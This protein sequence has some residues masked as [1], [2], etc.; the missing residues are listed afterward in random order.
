M[1]LAAGTRLGPYE[2]VAPLGAGGMGEVYRARDPRLGRDVAIKTV[3]GFISDEQSRRLEL[4][5]RATAALNH[6]NI[7]AVYDVGFASGLAYI[8][9]E[10]LEGENLRALLRRER[11]EVA[12]A[13]NIASQIAEALAAAHAKGIVHR[14]LKPENVFVLPGGRIKV[15]DFGLAKLIAADH[16][17]GASLETMSALTVAGEVVGTAAYLA[18]EQARGGAV[19]HRADIFSFG[20]VLYEMLAGHSPFRADTFADT[21]IA[22]LKEPTPPLPGDM[23]AAA[24]LD[25]IVRRCLEKHPDAR[26][27]S[28]TDLRFALESVSSLNAAAVSVGS[29]AAHVPEA[30]HRQ[31]RV[32]AVGAVLLAAAIAITVLTVIGWPF[33]LLGRKARQAPLRTSAQKPGRSV[34]E[35]VAVSA[36]LS[37]DVQTLQTR[38]ADLFDGGGIAVTRVDSTH[39]AVT[40]HEQQIDSVVSGIRI[41]DILR[42]QRDSAEPAAKYFGTN[43]YSGG[44]I[45]VAVRQA[46]VR[47]LLQLIA[48]SIGWSVILDPT[49]HGETTLSLTNVPWDQ[50]VATCL[51]SQRLGYA[52]SKDVWL[53]TSVSRAVEVTK[54]R[55][56]NP[57]AVRI[58]RSRKLGRPQLARALEP[59][60]T[61]EGLILTNARLNAVVIVD[62]ENAFADYAQILATVDGTGAAVLDSPV[63][64]ERGPR[65]SGAPVTFDFRNENV[66]EFVKRFSKIGGLNIVLDPG[67]VASA[68]GRFSGTLTNAPW[69]IVFDVGLQAASL[70]YVIQGNLVTIIPAPKEFPDRPVKVQAITLK[71]EVPAFFEPF[72]RYLSSQGSLTAEPQTRTLLI[73]DEGSRVN[74]L[75]FLI[76][77]ID[78]PASLVDP[79]SPAGPSTDKGVRK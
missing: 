28:A 44:R 57:L 72:R 77:S 52:R 25:R 22:I 35:T 8:V 1:P 10:L 76:R 11:L 63:P 56:G 71:R 12:R 27:Q 79:A 75:L 34:H 78:D 69:D 43:G 4:E 6:P 54:A 58:V 24:A 16:A 41:S 45:S 7:V 70:G 49:V 73:R 31:L 13:I 39:V 42:G 68:E 26:F 64:V 5:A 48:A 47:G 38:V 23:P 29:D 15:L 65:S 20:C 40:A 17:V 74:Q 55:N 66:E 21:L 33:D 14:D 3:R 62:H 51:T 67:V 60:R 59:A 53:V 9:T 61:N 19:G 50:V 32:L 36:S 18:P 2:I 37:S 30:R 46:S